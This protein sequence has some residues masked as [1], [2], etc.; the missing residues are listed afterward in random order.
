MMNRRNEYLERLVNGGHG[1]NP[2]EF[3]D[4][5]PACDEALA[6]INDDG[7]YFD[8]D[9]GCNIYWNYD[10]SVAVVVW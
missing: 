7:C 9:F 2:V 6:V 4:A 8:Y 3:T 10:H 1:C 5:E